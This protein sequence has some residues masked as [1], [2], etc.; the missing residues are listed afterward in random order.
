MPTSPGPGRR[1]DTISIDSSADSSSDTNPFHLR[2]HR[3]ALVAGSH[4]RIQSLAVN[5]RHNAKKRFS[6]VLKMKNIRNGLDVWQYRVA[7]IRQLAE[8]TTDMTREEPCGRTAAS[9]RVPRSHSRTV[10]SWPGQQ[11]WGAAEISRKSNNPAVGVK[12]QAPSSRSSVPLIQTQ[13]CR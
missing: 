8:K 1:E 4:T 9:L 5:V 13:L 12:T 11:A 3:T 10:P 7:V 6:P 2:L